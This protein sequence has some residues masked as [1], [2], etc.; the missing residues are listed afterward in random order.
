[1]DTRDG[2]NKDT[3]KNEWLNLSLGQNKKDP[4]SELR[5]VSLKVCHFCNRK[6]YSPQAL[7]GHQ[8]A[9]KRERDAAKRYHSL[10]MPAHPFLVDR[11]M[12]VQAHS[13]VHKP[14]RNAETSAATFQNTSAEYGA[15]LVQSEAGFAWQGSSY[16]DPHLASQPSDP[17]TLDLNLKL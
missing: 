3:Q 13:L 12:G 6:F 9:H 16:F 2:M 14:T 10:M 5:P 11:S 17:L 4:C 15:T 8:N 1:M 7:G